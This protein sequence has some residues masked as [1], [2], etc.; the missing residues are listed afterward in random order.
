MIAYY[1][2]QLKNTDKVK[3]IVDGLVSF[4]EDLPS[5]YKNNLAPYINNVLL[6]SIANQKMAL[7]NVS[8]DAAALQQQIDYINEKI[9]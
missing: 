2:I 5:I 7:K 6:K 8:P 4:R 9:K 1:A 3:K